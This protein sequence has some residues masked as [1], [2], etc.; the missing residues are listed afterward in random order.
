M[1]Y[2]WLIDKLSSKGW[3]KSNKKDKYMDVIIN[4]GGAMDKRI[5][6]LP[7]GLKNT[8]YHETMFNKWNMYQAMVKNGKS[9]IMAKSYIPGTFN[10]DMDKPYIIRPIG[11][12]GGKGIKVVKKLTPEF[13]KGLG[14]NDMIS[15]YIMDLDTVD[16]KVYHLR[17]H[18]IAAII[19]GVTLAY[20]DKK[21][22]GIFTAAKKW[23]KDKINDFGVHD[24]HFK[25]T[26]KI[27]YLKGPKIIENVCGG[28]KDVFSVFSDGFKAYA[29]AKNSF[30]IIGCDFMVRK[31]GEVVLI[32]T[33]RR[34]GLTAGTGA[35]Y[36]SMCQGI[37]RKFVSPVF[38]GE[39]LAHED[40]ASL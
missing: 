32:E 12:S 4:D 11:G 38:F 24:S 5:K 19:N 33:N 40:W 9:G 13:L 6:Y 20:M 35:M 29:E 23:D 3:V 8:L 26:D 30:M 18:M 36:E 28:C 39:E 10:G 31:N 16:G 21:Y 25:S 34:T 17:V 22:M 2:D 14:D 27:S 7:S 37:Y 1:N 15:E